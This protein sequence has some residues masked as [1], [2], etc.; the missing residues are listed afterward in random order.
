MTTP[1]VPRDHAH[2]VWDDRWPAAQL[3]GLSVIRMLTLPGP[4]DAMPDV[5]AAW[6]LEATRD[7]DGLAIIGE[8]V[9]VVERYFVSVA[10]QASIQFPPGAEP[11]L[12]TD[13]GVDA[14]LQ[15]YGP[16][17]SHALW[18][19]CRPF[20]FQVMSGLVLRAPVD[21]P[22]STPEP[23]LITTRLKRERAQQ[24]KRGK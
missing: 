10:A 1:Q 23:K 24:S 14:A 13:H 15:I 4:A 3:A 21:V 19:Y 9:R 2:L 12:D 11:R 8:A 18:D 16:W 22:I 6:H 20:L 5:P 17:V 7:G